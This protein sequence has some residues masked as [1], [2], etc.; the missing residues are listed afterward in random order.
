MRVVRFG[1]GV[2]A[3]SAGVVAVATAGAGSA[4]AG[5]PLIQIDQGRIGMSL[6][7]DE[8]AAVAGGPAPAVISMF[9]PVSKMGA[10]LQP[11][12]A[13]YK[14]ERGG[15]HASLRQVMSEAADHPDGSVVVYFNAPGTRGGRVL[16]VYQNWTEPGR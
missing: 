1:V 6:S 13:I 10:G 9:V 5:V 16:D 11:D 4:A 2:I 14:D 15:V 8:T 3:I 7:H 12:T